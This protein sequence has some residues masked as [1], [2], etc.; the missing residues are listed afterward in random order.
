MPENKLNKGKT[1]DGTTST[2]ATITYKGQTKEI[3]TWALEL[4]TNEHTLR[5]RLQALKKGEISWEECMANKAERH[6]FII[7]KRKKKRNEEFAEKRRLKA[8][9][10]L[11][12]DKIKKNL[13]VSIDNFLYK[14]LV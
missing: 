1:W 9:E 8:K 14:K 3:A 13:S 10:K 7:E 2:K 4:Q 6:Q 12:K 11:R 5:S